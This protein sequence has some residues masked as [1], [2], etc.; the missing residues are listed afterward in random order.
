MYSKIIGV[1]QNVLTDR[2]GDTIDCISQN[3][4]EFFN[5]VNLS[6]VLL[7]MGNLKLL[8]FF[9][10][11]IDF[12]GFVLTGGNDVYL[13]SLSEV[14]K[15]NS[16][17]RN[18]S[19]KLIVDFAIK[20]NKPTL[21]VCRGMQFINVYFGGELSKIKNHAGDFKHKIKSQININKMLPTE[22]NT[23]HNYGIPR[24]KCM[25]CF[26]ILALDEDGNVEAFKHKGK[27]LMGIMWHPERNI[28]HNELDLNLFK[29]FFND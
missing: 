8:K 21:G 10:N 7:P 15:R 16:D 13:E 2:H 12:R 4:Y 25:K 3:W 11:K 5:K 17:S 20:Y 18:K 28:P 26:D 29:S 23:F 24:V 6:P 9:L 1:T 14:E 27:N 19:E 22:V